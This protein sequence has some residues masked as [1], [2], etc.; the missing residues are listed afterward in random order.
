MSEYRF[1][2]KIRQIR[3]R[4]KITLKEI[5][6]KINVTESLLSQIERNKVSP[7]IDT[8]LKI[9]E[10][11]EID[12]EYLFSDY[13]IN[14][15]VNIVKK[16]NRKKISYN[17]VIYEQLSKTED[18]TEHGIEAY[19]LMIRKGGETGSKDYGHR[20]KEL[21]VI[22]EGSGEFLIGNNKYILEEGDS[23]SFSSSIPHVLRNIGDKDLKA[24]WIITPPKNFSGEI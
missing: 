19:F 12:L 8:L 21:G 2:D 7:A 24:L 23:I 9:A 4:K 18:D 11:L 17:N 1:G 5:A 6:E 13:K 22:L 3:E 14:K 16:D 15:K 10:V 20:G